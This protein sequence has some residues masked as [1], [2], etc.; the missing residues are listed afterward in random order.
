[1]RIPIK[2]S[3]VQLQLSKVFGL[4]SFMDSNPKRKLTESE[5]YTLIT[6]ALLPER[7]R[8]NRFS[9]LAK[10]KARESYKLFFGI[11][12]SIPNFSNK[13]YSLVDKGYI[14]RDEDGIMFINEKIMHLVSLLTTKG[15]IDIEM[16]YASEGS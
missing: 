15:Y 9:A 10:N 5:I 14:A 7:F 12:V 4:L 13:I 2:P 1:M 6:L 3:P 16:R 11:N 8:Y